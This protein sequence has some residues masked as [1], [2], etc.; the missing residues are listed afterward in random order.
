MRMMMR[1]EAL[2]SEIV[3]AIGISRQLVHYWCKAA[4]IVGKTAEARKA[5]VLGQLLKGSQ[6]TRPVKQTGRKARMRT[7]ADRAKRQW[8]R[9][10]AQ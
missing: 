2:P 10:H 8:D 9:R 5:R 6:S 3:E 7:V 1:G 4:G